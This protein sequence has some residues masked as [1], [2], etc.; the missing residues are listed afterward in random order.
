MFY[1]GFLGA[2]LIGLMIG[3]IIFS[4]VK[5]GLGFLTLI[6]LF[7]VYKFI[8]ASNNHGALKKILKE[9]GLE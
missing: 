9:K 5:S 6:L 1:M 4:V 3:I 7:I 2:T 8:N